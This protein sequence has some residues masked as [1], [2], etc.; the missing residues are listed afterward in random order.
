MTKLEKCRR[1]VNDAFR[2]NLHAAFKK[3]FDLELETTFNLGAMSLVSYLPDGA[4]FTPEQH[5][6]IAAYSGG[7]G[8]AMTQIHEQD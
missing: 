7:Y 2:E 1:R 4:P 5:D 8:A 3:K 6:F